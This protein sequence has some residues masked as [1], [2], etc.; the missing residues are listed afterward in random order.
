MSTGYLFVQVLSLALILHAPIS[1]A[2][3]IWLYRKK[4]SARQLALWVLI[5]LLFPVVGAIA[6]YLF[7]RRDSVNAAA[8]NA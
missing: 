3:L 5:V 8:G 4:S 6:T 2:T 7:V 1:L